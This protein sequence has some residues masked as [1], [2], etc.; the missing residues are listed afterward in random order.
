MNASGPEMV[1]SCRPLLALICVERDNPYGHPSARCLAILKE[2]G[3]NVLRTDQNGDIEVS[4]RSGKI[5]VTTGSGKNLSTT[6]AR[7]E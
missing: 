1:E 2:R 4:V 3:I 5:G 7:S 6:G